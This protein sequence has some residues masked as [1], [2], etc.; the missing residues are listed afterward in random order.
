MQDC[1]INYMWRQVLYTIFPTFTFFLWSFFSSHI[2]IIIPMWWYGLYRETDSEFY[3]Y[4]LQ[5][6]IGF[7]VVINNKCDHVWFW[8]Q[9][10]QGDSSVLCLWGWWWWCR[11]LLGSTKLN[12]NHRTI[13]L[14]SYVTVVEWRQSTSTIQ[15]RPWWQWG[16]FYF[17]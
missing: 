6:K 16:G 9:F 8:R 11:C 5:S 13:V 14:G 4:F 10:W 3:T 1:H 2:S 12:G 15:L 17:C 7:V